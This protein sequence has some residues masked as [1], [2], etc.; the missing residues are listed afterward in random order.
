MRAVIHIH[1]QLSVVKKNGHSRILENVTDD[2]R[3]FF[4]VAKK[5]KKKTD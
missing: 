5:K 3:Q 1:Y 2:A 4:W